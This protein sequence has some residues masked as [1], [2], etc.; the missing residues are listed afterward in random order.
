MPRE[1]IN[2]TPDNTGI[3][4]VGWGKLN[5]A[6]GEYGRVRVG[7]EAHSDPRNLGPIEAEDSWPLS[8]PELN[9]LIRVLKRARDQAFGNN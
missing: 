7:I 4:S 2:K 6:S 8:R 3:V 5:P 9:E 1:R